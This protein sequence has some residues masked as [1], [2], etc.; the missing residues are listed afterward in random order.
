MVKDKLNQI[1]KFLMDGI[2]DL[3]DSLDATSKSITSFQ[4]SLVKVN[5]VTGGKAVA[6]DKAASL[7]FNMLSTSPAGEAGQAT[8]GLPPA[9]K[10]APPSGPPRA[11]PPSSPPS[12][13]PK[14]G[15]PKS[16]PP[17]SPPSGPPSG[18]PRA[19]PPSAPSK[20]APKAPPSKLPPPPKLPP[21][22]GS[23]GP[24]SGPP[25]AVKT[26]SFAQ[27]PAAPSGSPS[28]AAPSGNSEPG[29][30]GLRDEMLKELER[31][32]KIMRGS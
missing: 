20:G 15:P 29:L 19:G 14:A 16:G 22:P 28:A 3:T 6:R 8:V 24:P 23:S 32:K 11:G 25:G 7:L 30:G 5:V 17:S 4:K 21:A 12:G 9:A 27:R 1:I 26:P 10:A 13:P 31:L 18:P 2:E